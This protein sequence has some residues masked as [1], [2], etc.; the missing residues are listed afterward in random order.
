MSF[1]RPELRARLWRWREVLNGAA[2]ALAGLWVFSF[3]GLFFQ[4]LGL[5]LI[6]L[7][8]GVGIV[9]LRRIRFRRLPTA[10]GVVEVVEGQITYLAP[11]GGGFAAQSELSEIVLD[12]D[13]QGT[14]HWQLSQTGGPRLT[15]PVDAVGAEA[16]F[17]TFVALPGAEPA[18]ILAALERP[19]AKGA[20]TV[21]RRRQH[22]ALT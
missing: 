12:F 9:A 13:A 5:L 8:A 22:L 6:V 19:A 14:A 10:P 11:E 20:V 21:W 2:L 15:I 3:G 4:G 16:L 1:V 17:D 18:R 7:G